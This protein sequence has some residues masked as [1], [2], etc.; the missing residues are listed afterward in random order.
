MFTGIIEDIGIVEQLNKSNEFLTLK[1]SSIKINKNVYIGDSISVNGVCLTV[2]DIESEGDKKVFG[3][4]VVHETLLKT[5]LDDLEIDSI[6]NLERAVKFSDRL[7]GHLVQ[8]HIED[9]G[10]IIQKKHLNNQVDLLIKLDSELMKYCIV[11]GSIA[12]DGISLTIA[13][14]I[15]NSIKVAIIPHTL[16]N[17]NLKSK[18]VDDTVNIETDIIAKYIE[19]LIERK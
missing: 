11:K 6:V 5:N 17:T 14:Q 19:N 15:D 4:S 13:D 8:G 18:A 7:N 16:E 2:D 9:V 1:I 12:I 3:F 10:T